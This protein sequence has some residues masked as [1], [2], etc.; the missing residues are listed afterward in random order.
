MKNTINL[1]L[2]TFFGLSN[3]LVNSLSPIAF[4]QTKN[5]V[6]FI[7]TNGFEQTSGRYFPTTY[8][9]THRG[10]IPVIRWKYGWFNN[11]ELTPEKRCQ[12]VSANFQAAYENGSLQYIANGSKNG[13]PVICTAR[14]NGGECITVLLTLRA[15]D[16]P[17]QIATDLKNILRG[18]GGSAIT[19][20]S[21]EKR[22]YYEI[23]MDK[24][25][26]TAPVEK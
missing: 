12:S 3:L 13:Q 9:W 1:A 21:G 25:L 4:A 5:Q 26:Q 6:R 16:D 2:I 23:D 14:Q 7:C 17:I 24:F 20:S 18:R 22:V 11:P 8:A 19:H 15:N 10:K